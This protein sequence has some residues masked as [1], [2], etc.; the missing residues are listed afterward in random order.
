MIGLLP[1]TAPIYAI[2][3]VIAIYFGI[4]VYVGRR[5]KTLLEKIPQGICAVCGDKIIDGKCPT[6]DKN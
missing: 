1:F 3:I 6:C 4:K 5:K 2:I